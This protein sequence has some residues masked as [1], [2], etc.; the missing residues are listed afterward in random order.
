MEI[1]YENNYD[2]LKSFYSR[3]D[4]IKAYDIYKAAPPDAKA[5]REK[6]LEKLCKARDIDITKLIKDETI[7]N[8]IPTREDLKEDLLQSFYNLYNKAPSPNDYM[9]RIVRRLAPEYNLDTVRVAILK[10]FIIGD[11][12]KCG[13]FDT[14]KVIEWAENRFSESEKKAYNRLKHLDRNK[15]LIS[16]IDDSI[17]DEMLADFTTKK[18]LNLII[19]CAKSYQKNEGF[20]FNDIELSPNTKIILASALEAS[21]DV[22]NST[23]ITQLESLFDKDMSANPSEFDKLV[24]EIEK[25]FKTQL[26]KIRRTNKNGKPSTVYKLYEESL[27]GAK[28]SNN[29]IT[30]CNDFATGIIKSNWKSSLYYFAFM[31]EMKLPLEG[32]D[33]PPEKNIIK[34]LFEDFYND[35]LLR[36]LSSR[37]KTSMNKGGYISEPTG[38]G[39][40]FKN[41]AE[42]IYIYYLNNDNL[43]LSPGEKIKISEEKIKECTD[44][45]EK[46]ENTVNQERLNETQY[47]KDNHLDIFLNLEMEHIV[48]YLLK[49]YIIPTDTNNK[50]LVASEEISATQFRAEILSELDEAYPNI[51]PFKVDPLDTIEKLRKVYLEDN[52]E[53][54][55]F[56]FNIYKFYN[57][58]VGKN[59]GNRFTN[60]EDLYKKILK[61][62]TKVGD[63]LDMDDIDIQM[64]LVLILLVGLAK[65][66]APVSLDILADSQLG[67]SMEDIIQAVYTLQ[68]MGFNIEEKDQKYYLGLMP[69]ETPIL[70]I[71]I[72]SLSVIFE[73]IFIKSTLYYDSLYYKNRFYDW[74][75]NELLKERFSDDEDFLIVLDEINKRVHVS[76]QEMGFNEEDRNDMLML[77]YY[78]VNKSSEEIPLT[79]YTLKSYLDIDSETPITKALNGLIALGFDLHKNNDKYYLKNRDYDNVIM[80]DIM[81]RLSNTSNY[82]SPEVDKAFTKLFLEKLQSDSKVTRCELLTTYLNYYIRLAMDT[83][84]LES[85]PDIFS[86]FEYSVNIYLTNARYQPLSKNNI[87]DM[88]IVTAL[89][90]YFV[91][92]MKL[93][94]KR[95]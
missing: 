77:L 41:F 32:I 95:N 86:D 24:S 20:V 66:D 1:L 69:L 2:I 89:Y 50:F 84:G 93:Y 30:M 80:N 40:N 22:Q 62:I 8:Q 19:N 72:E 68:N 39:I 45:A 70:N 23:I 67:Y 78:L 52:D 53:L 31:F 11:C 7:I 75:I 42:M 37:Y 36:F 83:N 81:K 85:F 44:R 92:N 91:E 17:F 34:N 46:G 82:K 90:F 48:D 74:K 29:L 13:I 18:Q 6:D 94:I 35:N 16:K 28:A 25:D 43:N 3:E 21:R 88:Y 9:K 15:L 87:F 26:R 33:C 49:E 12:K 58:T 5:F 55:K 4:F 59:I 14:K 71:F 65:E 57:W 10:K 63:E 51:E 56:R 79:K 38:E 27:K 47:F 61:E 76:A 73:S 60:K 54:T 64:I